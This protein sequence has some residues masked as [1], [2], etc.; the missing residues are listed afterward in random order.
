MPRAPATT[1]CLLLLAPVAHGQQ[2]AEPVLCPPETHPPQPVF[3]SAEAR[4]A[5]QARD[6]DRL[7]A[8]FDELQADSRLPG[9]SRGR[10]VSYQESLGWL[11]YLKAGH[12]DAWVAAKPESSRALSARG[13]AR[14]SWAWEARGYGWAREVTEEG[15]RLMRERLLLAK[16]DLERA[17]TLDPRSHAAPAALI[18]VAM[19]LS[20]GRDKA[21]EYLR[22]AEAADPTEAV[23]H[24]K[25]VTFLLPKWFGGERDALEFAR[26]AVAARPEEPSRLRLIIL[27]HEQLASDLP[28]DAQ[29]RYFQQPAVRQEVA[30]A[31][32]RLRAAYPIDWYLLDKQAEF[33]RQLG[34][35]AGRLAALQ[36]SVDL[37]DTDAMFSLARI[38]DRNVAG[39]PPDLVRA[40]RL[41]CRAAHAGHGEAKAQLAAFLLEGRGGVPQDPVRAVTLLREAAEESAPDALYLL[42]CV[43]YYGE[44]GVRRDPRAG[45]ELVERAFKVGH[46]EARGLVGLWLLEAGD[47]RRG[48]DLLQEAVRQG[49]RRAALRLGRLVESGDL[50]VQRDL[51]T[52]ANLY[53]RGASLGDAEARACLRDLLTLHPGLRRPGDPH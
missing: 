37:G 42:G 48:V 11:G 29:M 53:R 17:M 21:L 9:V 35:L 7:E 23:A 38:I 4:A 20:L 10:Y 16:A 52:A 22:R 28:D 32:E 8:V 49:G 14:I 30:H 26:A 15:W 50:R 6:F 25:M 19:G 39:T 44:A 13:K 27:A 18:T 33:A 12:L 43:T 1:L 36:V 51:S 2:G 46:I 45:R 40:A 34:D 47:G 24:E 31:F 41:L 5:L 3:R